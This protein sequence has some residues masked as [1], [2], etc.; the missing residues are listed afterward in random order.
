MRRGFTLIELMIA[1][2]IIAIVAAIAIPNLLE[3]RKQANESNA[4]AA[5]RTYGAAQYIYRK[6]NYSA[7]NSLPPKRYCPQ[8]AFLGGAN[9]HVNGAGIRLTLIADDFAAATPTGVPYQGYVFWD[10]QSLQF[11][12]WDSVFGLYADPA[13]YGAS[14]TNSFFMNACG[15]VYM[16]DLGAGG[17][18]GAALVDNTWN[19]P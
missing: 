7:C 16:K 8:C 4:I 17:S 3:S 1:V 14:G 15:V 18:S 11:V 12:V 5:L 9:A 13:V 2:A 19:V 6:A 10:D